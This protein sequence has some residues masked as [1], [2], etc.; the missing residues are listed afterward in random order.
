MVADKSVHCLRSC[1]GLAVDPQVGRNIRRSRR[2][3]RL[4]G[5]NEIRQQDIIDL[6]TEAVVFAGVTNFLGVEDSGRVAVLNEDG[7]DVGVAQHFLQFVTGGNGPG[8]TGLQ[9]AGSEYLSN[10]ETFSGEVVVAASVS[11][12]GV[13][14]ENKPPTAVGWLRALGDDGEFGVRAPDRAEVVGDL[15]LRAATARV[16]SASASTVLSLMTEIW[17]VGVVHE[18]LAAYGFISW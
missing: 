13:V 7:N 10:G 6:V 2:V 5:V 8:C 1:A 3:R 11:L 16:T 9:S 4:V 15:L 14:K 18:W 12:V 17:I